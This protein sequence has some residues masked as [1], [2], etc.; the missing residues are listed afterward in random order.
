MSVSLALIARNA[1]DTLG[2]AIE[3]V[4]DYVDAIVVV[5]AGQSTDETEKVA[6]RYT[7][8][9]IPFK[10]CD[11]FSAARQVSFDACTGDW[12]FWIDADDE[13]VG[14]AQLPGLVREAEEKGWGAVILRYAYQ[15]DDHENVL[16]EHGQHRLLRRNLGWFWGCTCRKH[17]G[18]VHEVSMAEGDH[19]IV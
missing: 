10:W 14:G 1:A 16:V 13:V 17:P 7:H 8:K 11:D 9:V 15:K 12:I 2:P 18:R 4:K 19:A 5:L 6:R 3:S